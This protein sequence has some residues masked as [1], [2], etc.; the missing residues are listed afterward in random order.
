MIFSIAVLQANRT[1]LLEAVWHRHKSIIHYFVEEVKVDT[2]NMT[3]VISLVVHDNNI[4]FMLLY[5]SLIL[6]ALLQYIKQWM[7]RQLEEYKKE[8]MSPGKLPDYGKNAVLK[9]YKW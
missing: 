9:Y 3:K 4:V 8:P 6:Y 2:T 5:T 1:P 7:E